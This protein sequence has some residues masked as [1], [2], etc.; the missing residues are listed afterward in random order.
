MLSLWGKVKYTAVGVGI[1]TYVAVFFLEEL[2]RGLGRARAR[3][4][5]KAVRDVWV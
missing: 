1:C 2:G 5:M 3:A 4:R